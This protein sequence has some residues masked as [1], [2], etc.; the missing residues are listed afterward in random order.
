MTKS[1]KHY[2]FP[3]TKKN[4]KVCETASTLTTNKIN[5]YRSEIDADL[6][7]IDEAIAEAVFKE[8]M[9]AHA[10]K[11]DEALDLYTRMAS[12]AFGIPASEVTKDQ[13]ALTKSRMLLEMYSTDKHDEEEVAKAI[14]FKNL[15]DQ[16]KSNK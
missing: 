4:C 7:A 9:D 14:T 1:N 13:R 11:E 3:H 8:L 15:L 2:R 5:A 6:V 16:I 10:K 12:A